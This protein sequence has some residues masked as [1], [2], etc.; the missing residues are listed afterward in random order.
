[1]GIIKTEVKLSK[2]KNIFGGSYV[3]LPEKIKNKQACVNIKN[4]DDKCFYWS[5]VAFKHYDEIKSKSKNEVRHYKKY[6]GSIKYPEWFS[7]PVE[8]QAI[9][10]WEEAND[11][12]I[13]VFVLDD[14]NNIKIEYHSCFKTKNVCNLLLYKEHFV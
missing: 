6:E 11:I 9:G 14:E 13:N 7:Y 4:D 10:M 5:L 8:I 12:K 1:L 3:E 2:S